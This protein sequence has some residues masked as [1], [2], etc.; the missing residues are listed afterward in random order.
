MT[1]GEPDFEEFELELYEVEM[2]CSGSLEDDKGSAS[3]SRDARRD[4]LMKS[5]S[6]WNGEV[7]F[8]GV[9]IIRT[10]ESY[11]AEKEVE[12]CFVTV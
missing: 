5:S 7:L 2:M 12:G 4:L 8:A 9:G 11:D 3:A 1:D 6:G 10:F